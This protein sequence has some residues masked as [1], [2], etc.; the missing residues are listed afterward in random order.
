MDNDDYIQYNAILARNIKNYS[1]KRMSFEDMLAYVFMSF[2]AVDNGI[3]DI[4]EETKRYYKNKSFYY[5]IKYAEQ[6]ALLTF[7][8]E[9]YSSI[10]N[11]AIKPKVQHGEITTDDTT[12]F[13]GKT[14]T[15]GTINEDVKR[16]DEFMKCVNKVVQSQKLTI[17]INSALQMGTDIFLQ[18]KNNV[19]CIDDISRQ[20]GAIHVRNNKNRQDDS[21]FLKP[22]I[23]SIDLKKQELY[24][25]H[26]EDRIYTLCRLI[27]ICNRLAHSYNHTIKDFIY[28][29]LYPKDAL[30]SNKLQVMQSY[31]FN[32]LVNSI[33]EYCNILSSMARG[34]RK[35]NS[36]RRLDVIIRKVRKNLQ[37][38][39]IEKD[40]D[41]GKMYEFIEQYKT[42]KEKCYLAK[43]ELIIYT[44]EK[45]K[46][47]NKKTPGLYSYGLIQK[48][49]TKSHGNQKIDNVLVVN[50]PK[51]GQFAFHIVSDEILR[52]I[53]QIYDEE[54]PIIKKTYGGRNSK[55][56]PIPL[57][58]I[59]DELKNYIETIG[60][61]DELIK[62]IANTDDSFNDKRDSIFNVLLNYGYSIDIIKEK[63]SD[64]DKKYGNDSIRS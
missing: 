14:E 6:E 11:E 38:A 12:S 41:F 43:N 31:S 59:S 7:I 48:I 9:I 51:Y 39:G 63:L 1:R 58:G 55:Q 8:H 19:E 37:Q 24:Y 30:E 33:H 54:L 61:I 10:N 27:R 60:G 21:F 42:L 2:L 36:F 28:N 3:L 20:S 44:I 18:L 47:G 64:F 52:H 49:V 50:V 35:S 56:P 13:I 22:S 25:E 5:E 26:D 46:E 17:N 62:Q 34:D 4:N 57:K 15:L 40:I 45:M 53:S 29:N 23:R 32:E 16:F